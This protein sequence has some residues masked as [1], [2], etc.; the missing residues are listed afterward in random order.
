V[1]PNGEL[2]PVGGGDPIP[3]IRE[4]LT[5]GRRDSCDVCLRFP[6]ISGL[7]CELVF[8][9]GVWYV[10]DLGSTNG[11]KVNDVRVQEKALRPGDRLAI[12]KRVYTVRYVMTGKPEEV[13][14]GT[15]KEQEKAEDM[16]GQSLLERAGLARPQSSREPGPASRPQP[17]RPGRLDRPL[18]PDDVQIRRRDEDDE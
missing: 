8:R 16:W 7:H 17:S 3:L 1:K 10:R 12:A 18:N 13:G 11:T 4:Q 6:N 14:P 5:I 15:A 9:S 2:I